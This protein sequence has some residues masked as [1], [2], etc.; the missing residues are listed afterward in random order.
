[1]SPDDTVGQVKRVILDM[2][3]EDFAWL[4]ALISQE[5]SVPRRFEHLLYDGWSDLVVVPAVAKE[6]KR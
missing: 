5:S 4:K 6:A 1:V 2:S 3:I